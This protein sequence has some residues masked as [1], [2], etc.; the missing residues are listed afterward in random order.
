MKA[1]IP[2]SLLMLVCILIVSAAQAQ[3]KGFSIGP[4][5]EGVWPTGGFENTHKR[6]IGAGVGAD[7]KLPAR[8]G[9]SASIGYLHIPGDR[10]EGGK[11]ETINAVPLRAG[12]KYRFTG[13]YLKLESGVAKHMNQGVAP[14]II[15]PGIG[16]RVL[17]LDIQ[18]KFET[19]IK[20]DTWSFWGL[21]ASYQ[22]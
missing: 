11:A 20:S 7:L 16:V 2:R 13:M 6:G 17:G 8:L 19:W 18:G 15:A 4:Y 9:L 3:L 22:F 14:V 21:K 10:I 5:V 1:A 12:I